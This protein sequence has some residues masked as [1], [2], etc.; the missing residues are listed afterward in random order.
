MSANIHRTIFHDMPNAAMIL[1][2]DLVYVD[3]NDAYCRAVGRSLDELLGN[4]IFDVFP[5]TEERVAQVLK[6]FERTLAGDA[7]R[8]TTLSNGNAR[9]QC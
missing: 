4:Y 1:D 6:V 3:A 5:D 8:G 7:A 2:T 9:R